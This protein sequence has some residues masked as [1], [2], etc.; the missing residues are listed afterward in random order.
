MGTTIEACMNEGSQRLTS[1]GKPT[2]PIS[3]K[4][5]FYEDSFGE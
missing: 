5:L 1:L 2:E 3:D 4:Y